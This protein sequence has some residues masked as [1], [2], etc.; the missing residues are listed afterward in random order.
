MVLVGIPHPLWVLDL[1]PADPFEGLGDQVEYPVGKMGSPVIDRTARNFPVG[2]PPI[3]L[4]PVAVD[5]SF[6]AEDPAD[7]FFLLYQLP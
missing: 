6:D 5:T 1:V 4:G 3:T 2:T 7:P